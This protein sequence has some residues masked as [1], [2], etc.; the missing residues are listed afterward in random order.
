MGEGEHTIIGKIPRERLNQIASR[1]LS[2]LGIPVRLG[3]DRETL[4]GELAL[5]PRLV[6]PATGRPLQRARFAVAGHDHLRFL[7]PP[8]SAL[9]PV[10][11]FDEERAAGVENGIA[12]ALHARA[13]ALNDL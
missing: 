9:P 2:T 5:S 10:G 4:E 6:H 11:F 12:A 13:A 8:L 1:K 3:A 7:D